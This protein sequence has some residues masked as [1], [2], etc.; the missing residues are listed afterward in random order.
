MENHRPDAAFLRMDAVVDGDNPRVRR[1]A[2]QLT[3]DDPVATAE[4]CF[5]FVR[6]KILHSVDFAREEMPVSASAVLDAGSA[7]CLAKSHLLVA[8]W[9]AC[10]L[11]S[12]FCYQRLRSDDPDRYVTHGLAAVWLPESGWYRCDA[13]GNTKP[14]IE[15]V[16]TPGTES[17]AYIPTHE[18][19][20]DD[21]DVW[22]R[23]WPQVV[24]GLEGMTSLSQYLAQP[25]DAAPPKADHLRVR[26][27]AA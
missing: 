12:G 26:A 6:D 25:I 14:G 13:R 16:F 27:R 22:A 24:A 18:G 19:E 15:C 20:Q 1:I 8:L 21:L 23:P 5:T 7:L 9:R 2:E 10:G 17:L 4:R 11:P 3:R